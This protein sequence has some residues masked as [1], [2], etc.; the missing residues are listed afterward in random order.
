MKENIKVVNNNGF[1]VGLRC[2]DWHK[3]REVKPYGFI[4]LTE[5]EVFEI[6]G[7]TP[8]FKD[9]TLVILDEEVKTGLGYEEKNPNAITEEEILEIFKHIPL[10]MKKELSGITEDFAKGKILELAKKSDLS[11][12]KL[13]IVEEI[14]GKKIN[15]DDIKVD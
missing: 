6:D 12:S 4:Y 7:N 10:K 8:Y 1:H 14:T 3:D 13:K 11:P 2:Y 15:L 9:G 5:K